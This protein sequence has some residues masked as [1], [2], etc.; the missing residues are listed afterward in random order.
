VA[1]VNDFNAQIIEEYRAKG[2]KLEGQFE[3][4]PMLLLHHKG[5]KTGAERVNPVAYRREGDSLVVFASKAGGPTNP[6]WY[7]NLLAHPETTVEVG[8]E[9][10]P[11]VAHVASDAEREPLWE[12]QK[13]DVPGFADYEKQTERKIPVVILEPAR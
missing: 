6:D 1:D 9:T 7:Y 3:G 8:A 4:A 12:A 11:V 10:I 5:A 2:G 13:R